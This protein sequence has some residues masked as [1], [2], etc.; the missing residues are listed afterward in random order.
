M[1]SLEEVWA[2]REE[3][4]YPALF[5]VAR[6]G[7]FP[8]DTKI[9][10]ETFAQDEIDPR[11]L[12][13]G[14]MEF[15]PS[16][17]RASWLYVSSGGSTPWETEPSEYCI[18]DYSWIGVE[19]VLE[20]PAQADWPVQALRRLL[21]YQVLL[22]HGRF[23]GYSPI[24]YGHRLPAGG[25]IDGSAHSPLTFMAIAKAVHYPSSATLESGKFDFLHVVG[26]LSK[27]AILRKRHQPRN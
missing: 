26:S 22:A 8:L 16:P 24:D 11:W 25:A 1:S 17:S 3:L 27:S 15:E 14:I 21:A 10:A 2:F 7:I 18:D 4:L 9:F 6:R 13:L 5:G 20:A 12:H 23:D 19:F